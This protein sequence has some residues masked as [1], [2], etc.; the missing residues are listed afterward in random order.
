[1]LGDIA[2]NTAARDYSVKG[3]PQLFLIGPDG[4]IIARELQLRGPAL[5]ATVAAALG[6]Q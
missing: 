1:M 2:T 5:A 6:S 4:R 3:I